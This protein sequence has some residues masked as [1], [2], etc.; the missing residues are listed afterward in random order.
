MTRI[1]DVFFS[2]LALLVLA[3]L[4]VPVMVLL[5]FT[6]EGH[7]FYTQKRVG[8]SGKLF[9]LLKFATMLKDSPNIGSGHITLMH[10]PRVLPVGRFLRKTK[11]N[12]LPQ[13]IN[14]FKGDMSIV[15]PRPLTERNF[16]YY[17]EKDRQIISGVR[18][19]LTGVGS[20]VFRDEEC[21]LNQQQNPLQYYQN[22]IAPYK[23]E[24]ELWYLR[25]K[26]LSMYFKLIL[27]TGLVVAFPDDKL[28]DHWL[29]DKPVMPK[30]INKVGF[31]KSKP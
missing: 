6:G 13:I 12:E 8:M 7:V 5:R 26:S 16:N 20:I 9:D 29:A 23:A 17:A 15:G 31:R 4:L 10:D 28:V 24:L 11:I 3:P 1:C 30:E 19:G 14:I 2:G 18:P 25:N 21:Y 27:L 22:V